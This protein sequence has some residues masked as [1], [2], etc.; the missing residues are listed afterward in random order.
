MTR[1]ERMERRAEQRR[2]WADKRRKKS[3][4]AYARATEISS[5]IVPGQPVLCGH[6]SEKRHRADLAKIDGA[7]RASVDSSDMAKHHDSRAAGIEDQLER[8]VFSDDPDAVEQL[9]AKIEA[10][11]Q[12][13][14]RM[15]AA[16][17]IVRKFAKDQHNG[18]LALEQAGF[19]AGQAER[20]FTP[21]QC[22]GMGF[23]R[24]AL[25]NNGANIRRMQERVRAI[26]ATN[27]RKAAAEQSEHGVTIEGGDYVR[28]TFAE[29]PA[30]EILDALRTAGFSWRA[31]SWIGKRA[32]LPACVLELAGIENKEQQV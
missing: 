9:T 2:E 31:P 15:K 8:S 32:S 22:H 30:R 21:D 28:V 18:R 14:E 11:E 10:A 19:T 12:L 26:T 20:L 7:M 5:Y 4:A 3:D 17:K 24:Y 6:H 27:A 16:N 23:P 29:K 13:Q 1:R 25:T